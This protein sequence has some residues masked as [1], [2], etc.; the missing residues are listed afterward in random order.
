MWTFILYL[1]LFLS[2]VSVGLCSLLKT[3]FGGAGVARCGGVPN[4]AVSVKY[5]FNIVLVYLNWS[6]EHEKSA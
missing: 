6:I 4:G 1:N 5:F 2:F 3:Y